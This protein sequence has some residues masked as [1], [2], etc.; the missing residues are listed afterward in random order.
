[1]KISRRPLST[2]ERE[3]LAKLREMKDRA[4]IQQ[5]SFEELSTREDRYG[6][7]CPPVLRD[8]LRF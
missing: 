5:Q 2:H 8:I 7:E 4:P 6:H 3:I 1:M